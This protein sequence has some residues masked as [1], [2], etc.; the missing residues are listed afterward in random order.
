MLSEDEGRTWYG[1]LV[2]D[3]RSAVS[4]PDGIEDSDGRCYII[5]DRDRSQAK[6]I[7]MAVFTEGDVEAG[8]PIS[9]LSR[10]KQ[11]VDRVPT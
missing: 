7:L 1:H 3:E 11:V 6:E 5:Y 10:L 8:K 9:K 4:Y 2:L